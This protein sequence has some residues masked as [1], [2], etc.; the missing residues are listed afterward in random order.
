MRTPTGNLFITIE[1]GDGAG[2]STLIA[3]L[4]THLLERGHRVTTT[5]EPGGTSLGQGL[6]SLLLDPT[7]EPMSPITELSLLLAD[8]AHHL[9]HVIVPALHRGEFVISD[10]YIDSSYVYQGVGRGLLKSTIRRMHEMMMVVREP[11]L[12]L[13]VDVPAEIA[14]A[15]VEASGSRDRIEAEG[16]DFY[17]RIRAGYL[18]RAEE[19]THRFRVIDGMLPPNAI[20]AEAAAIVDERLRGAVC[21]A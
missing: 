1:G 19:R 5:C 15:R 9:E 14:M 2:K 8:R 7:C 3:S 21:G 6:R 4:R 20:A 11:D 12:T 18:D 13:L 10:R 16:L 17:Q